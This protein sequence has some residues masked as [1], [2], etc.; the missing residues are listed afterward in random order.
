[1][2]GYFDTFTLAVVVSK[3]QP[4]R[5]KCY[6]L[7]QKKG[8][9]QPWKVIGHG[10]V[11]SLVRTAPNVGIVWDLVAQSLVVNR[12]CS[13]SGTTTVSWA[14]S[15]GGSMR[16]SWFDADS[17]QRL[18]KANMQVSDH[19]TMTWQTPPRTTNEQYDSTL[20]LVTFT[21]PVF[22][23]FENGVIYQYFTGCTP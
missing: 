5:M 18:Q 2:K 8:R 13:A 4:S 16:V 1:V 19:G 11:A 23:M 9:L 12:Q 10:S 7:L 22:S 15:P 14:Y 3:N 6:V 21:D 17:E 20:N